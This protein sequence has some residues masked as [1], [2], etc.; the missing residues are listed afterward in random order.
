MV[1]YNA[2]LYGGSFQRKKVR[3][4]ALR[5][6]VAVDTDIDS[7]THILNLTLTARS[8]DLKTKQV[9]RCDLG[10]LTASTYMI[11]AISEK[12]QDML[13]GLVGGSEFKSDRALVIEAVEI[14]QHARCKGLAASLYEIA[15][16]WSTRYGLVLLPYES[17]STNGTSWEAWRVWSR[18]WSLYTRNGWATV[19]VP[20]AGFETWDE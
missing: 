8:K 9:S 16:A 13:I 4:S 17:V 11:D 20:N 1:L 5:V 6:N 10:R 15:L 7:D 19:A 12:A 14:A 18:I 3:Y 2:L